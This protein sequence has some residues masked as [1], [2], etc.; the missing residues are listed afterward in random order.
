MKLEHSFDIAAEPDVAWKTLLDIPRITPCM[1]GAELTE[2]IDPNKFKG[3]AKVKLGPVQLQFAGDAEIK[4]ID[5][6]NHR[7]RL[8]ASGK[9]AKGRG[10]ANAEVIFNLVD[11]GEGRTR[12]DMKADLALTG[13]VAQYGRATGLIDEIAKQLIS[14]FANNLESELA[15]E[16]GINYE[17]E[18]AEDDQNL[19]AKADGDKTFDS[20]TR[21]ADSSNAVSG[22]G[23]LFRSL[24]A[25][26][27]RL[28][29]RK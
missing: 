18:T 10:S 12:V 1:P 8:V 4:E 23:L 5:D 3:A 22:F 14:D 17:V 15:S 24:W 29:S 7:A 21:K 16:G 19:Q 26:I 2:I 27:T 20:E 13:S 6:D 11:A 9:D 28:F 25:M